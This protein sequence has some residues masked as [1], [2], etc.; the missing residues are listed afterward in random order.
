MTTSL[1]GEE[2]KFLMRGA[3]ESK[4]EVVI[5]GAGLAGLSSAYHLSPEKF[6][7]LVVEKSGG[8]GGT[9]RSVQVDGFTFDVTG[10]LL[11]LHSDYTKNL[12][13]N[14]LKDNLYTCTRNA[15]IYSKG[16]L[17]PYPFQAHTRGL[18]R[19]VAS[20]CVDGFKEAVRKYSAPE[21]RPTSLPFSAW[22]LRTFGAGIHKHFMKPYNEKLWQVRLS[23]MTAEW[24]GMFVPQP[25]V[26]DVVKGSKKNA[27]KTFGYN[28]TF[29]YPKR[30]GI[31]VLAQALGRNLKVEL[32]TSFEEVLWK[33]KRVRLSNGEW[34]PYDFLVSTVPLVELLKRMKD[35]PPAIEEIIPRLKW[36]SVLCVNLGVARPKI[37]ERSWVYFPEKKYIFYRVGF[38]MNFTPHAVP[39]GCS[40][41]YVEVAHSPQQKLDWQSPKFMARIRKDLESSGILRKSDRIVVT[42]FIPIR[43]AYVVYTPER[44]AQ[45]ETIFEFFRENGIFSIGRYGEWK[46]SFMEEAILDGKKTAEKIEALSL[47]A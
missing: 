17:T 11:H 1:D 8:V 10:H 22:S 32:N 35:L 46:Y 12:I 30:G 4:K 18:P 6:Q 44:K 21:K 42:N 41:M 20:E 2:R 38:P 36:T 33:E 7:T 40:S 37:S 27:S 43:Y 26:E 5:L 9:A 39:E 25:K 45:M 23:E 14:L 29:L 34:K 19:K 28:A 16:V 31:Q 3:M 47:P 13:Q 15:A 24:C